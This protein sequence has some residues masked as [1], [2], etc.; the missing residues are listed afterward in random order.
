MS[1]NAIEGN[2]YGELK[3]ENSKTI[4]PLPV[5]NVFGLGPAG[6]VANKLNQVLTSNYVKD[7][8]FNIDG[9]EYEFYT[10][11]ANKTNLAPWLALGGFGLLLIVLSRR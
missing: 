10:E 5:F 8:T 7:K 1:V 9:K 6:L 3:P 11:S 2:Y 4:L